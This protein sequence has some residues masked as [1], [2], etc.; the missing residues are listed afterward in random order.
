MAATGNRKSGCLWHNRAS[1]NLSPDFRGPDLGYVGT[2]IA[3]E[4]ST[5]PESPPVLHL[6]ESIPD[7][8]FKSTNSL[9][10]SSPTARGI[11]IKH[12]PSLDYF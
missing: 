6:V 10:D 8:I 1:Q 12:H 5:L 2:Q 3:Q 9:V 11:R 4:L 7:A